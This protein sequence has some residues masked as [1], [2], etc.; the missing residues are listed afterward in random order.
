MDWGEGSILNGGMKGNEERSWIYTGGR[1]ESVIDY[2]LMEEGSKEKVVSLE[3][4]DYVESF[5]TN[6]W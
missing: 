1:G 2:V 6:R 5:V 4:K 3:I